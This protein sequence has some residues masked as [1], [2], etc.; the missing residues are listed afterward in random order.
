MLQ[1]VF[2]L[3]KIFDDPFAFFLLLLVFSSNCRSV[4]IV[5]GAGL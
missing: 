3:R 5:N 2:E 1:L 4:D